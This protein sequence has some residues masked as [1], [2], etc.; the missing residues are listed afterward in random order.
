MSK[1]GFIEAVLLRLKSEIV[2]HKT[3]IDSFLENPLVSLK[4]DTYLSDIVEHAK[5]MAVCENTFRVLTLT[6]VQQE[7]QQEEQQEEQKTDLTTPSAEEAIV[8]TPERSPTYKRSLE[9]Q[10]IKKK[11]QRRSRKKKE[12]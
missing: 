2:E 4:E 7:V 11:A 1:E 12:E 6:Y 9:T 8:L 3:I 5:A 10:E